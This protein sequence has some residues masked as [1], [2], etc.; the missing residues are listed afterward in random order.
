MKALLKV[1]YTNDQYCDKISVPPVQTVS[2]KY[3]CISITKAPPNEKI[4]MIV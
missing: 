4:S 3:N 1:K 2:G